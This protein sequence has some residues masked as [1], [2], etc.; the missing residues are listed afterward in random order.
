[1]ALE[2]IQGKARESGLTPS[3]Y[4]NAQGNVHPLL[5]KEIPPGLELLPGKESQYVLVRSSAELTGATLVEAKVQ[6]GDQYGFPV[7]ALEFNPEGARVFARVTELNIGKN[8]AIVLDGIVQS[9]PVIRTRIPDGRA[10]IEGN[11]TADDA[12]LLATVLRAGALP[13]PVRIIEER[14]VGPTLGEDSIRSGVRA[15]LVGLALVVGFMA[16]YY[17]TSG[18]IADL[19][20]VLNLFLLLGAM[21]YFHATLTLPGIAGVLLSLAMAVDAN[22]LIL[23]RVREELRLGKT[24]RTAIDFGY[25]RAFSAILDGNLTTLIAAA[26]LFQFGS[27]PVKGFAVTLALGLVISMF[28]AITGT[29]TLY[30]LWLSGRKIERLSV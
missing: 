21:A 7:V 22:V 13:A 23:E 9:A 19:A 25:E 5:A 24:V 18:L 12:K 14:T 3:E 11:F 10:V 1:D 15:C 2:K 27:G 17:K 6:L 20:L 30:D 8:L 16:M 29:K 4:V 28:T 26:F